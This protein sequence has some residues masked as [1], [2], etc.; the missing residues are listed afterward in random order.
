MT[1]PEIARG[2]TA[3]VYDM[4]DGRVLKLFNEGY[5]RSAALREYNYARIV[6]E[7]GIPAP[8]VYEFVEP[9]GRVGIVYEKIEGESM[10]DALLGGGD[11]PALIADFARL[12]KQFHVAHAPEL[13]SLKDSWRESQAD[14]RRIGLLPAG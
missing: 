3:I 7:K 11:I 10:L 12:H 1:Y 9:E 4:G 5:W 13:R 6:G 14:H 8:Q 2:A